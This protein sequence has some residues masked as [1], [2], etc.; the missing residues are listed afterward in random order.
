MIY[1]ILDK[2][3]YI[4]CY[5]E[6]YSIYKAIFIGVAV[7]VMITLCILSKFFSTK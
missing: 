7:L 2:A 5:S 6:G 1:D 3:D 4:V